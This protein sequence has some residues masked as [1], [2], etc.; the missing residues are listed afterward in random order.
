MVVGIVLVIVFIGLVVFFFFNLLTR[1]LNLSSESSSFFNTVN[2]LHTNIILRNKQ[3]LE[4]NQQVINLSR[5]L[6][7]EN[8]KM[9][10]IL[11]EIH[12]TLEEEV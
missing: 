8:A 5:E 1:I 4:Q 2:D 10:K 11:E 9:A 7:E 3:I 6:L 12:N